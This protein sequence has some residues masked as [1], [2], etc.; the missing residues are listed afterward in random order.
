MVQLF[1]QTSKQIIVYLNFSIRKLK[2]E[3]QTASLEV[4]RQQRE[5]ETAGASTEG[6]ANPYIID[7][8][9]HVA[10]HAVNGI[11]PLDGISPPVYSYAT[12]TEI[13][14]PPPYR[15]KDIP[16][17]S[18]NLYIVENEGYEKGNDPALEPYTVSNMNGNI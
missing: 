5:V 11:L 8:S 10:N 9:Q 1:S 4:L 16:T 7:N 18:D 12:A 15:P 14:A 2:E 17:R 13:D 6:H 3:E